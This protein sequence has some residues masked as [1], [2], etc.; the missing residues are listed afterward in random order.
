MGVR[1]S[2]QDPRRQPLLGRAG[3]AGVAEERVPSQS[4][5]NG[6]CLCRMFLY[7]PTD[8]PGPGP[9]PSPYLFSSLSSR[10][11]RKSFYACAPGACALQMR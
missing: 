11:G 1:G 4:S 6:H 7:P 2:A 3:V 10:K 9:S 5:C 8:S